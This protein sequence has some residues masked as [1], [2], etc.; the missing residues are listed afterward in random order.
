MNCIR[1]SA[2]FLY[3]KINNSEMIA[4][5]NVPAGIQIVKYEECI[6]FG[7][8]PLVLLSSISTTSRPRAW[9]V[10]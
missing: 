3:K 2:L 9:D 1:L 4:S 7:G 8:Q 10:N 6:L 5:V